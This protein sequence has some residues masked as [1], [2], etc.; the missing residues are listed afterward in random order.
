MTFEEIDS[1]ARVGQA[2]QPEPVIRKPSVLPTLA[3]E[4]T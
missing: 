3:E 1:L 4:V 2:G